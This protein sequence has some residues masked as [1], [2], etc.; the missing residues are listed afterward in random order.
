MVKLAGTLRQNRRLREM[1]MLD[2][3]GLFNTTLHTK[4][5]SMDTRYPNKLV[6]EEVE[7][8]KP[9]LKEEV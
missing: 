8:I 3:N 6:P 1:R 4:T 7:K 5:S 2:F 9:L